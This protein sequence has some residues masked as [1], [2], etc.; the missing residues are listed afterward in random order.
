MLLFAA[1][2]FYPLAVLWLMVVGFTTAA[3]A[4]LNTTMLFTVSDR[5]YYGRVMSVN[6]LNMSFA[7]VGAF[8]TGYLIDW[9]PAISLGSLTLEPVQVVY[10]GV[11]LLIALFILGVTLFNPTY[12]RFGKED[13]AV[14][15]QPVEQPMAAPE[16]AGQSASASQPP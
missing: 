6:M 16:P 8:L 15:S 4:S 2:G 10:A 13:A 9:A 14:E 12:R 5:A 3:L 7:F 11:G 1:T